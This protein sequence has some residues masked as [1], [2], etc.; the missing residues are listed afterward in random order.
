MFRKNVF[1][2][3][4]IGNITENDLI[5]NGWD[6][7][8]WSGNDSDY[9]VRQSDIQRPDRISDTVYGT[10][11]YWWVIMKYNKI[12]DVWNDLKVGSTLKI[13][14]KTEIDKFYIAST[15]RENLR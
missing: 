10:N 8:T 9:T 2:K 15:K 4:R 6:S 7:W 1:K 14:P 12:D 3:H 11:R 5:D 13:P